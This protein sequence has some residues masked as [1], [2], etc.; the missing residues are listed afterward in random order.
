LTEADQFSKR[1]RE[2]I[3]LLLQG[4]GNKQI[5]LALGITERTVEFHL[6][7]VYAKLHVSSAREAILKLGKSTV[8]ENKTKLGEST[9]V[10]EGGSTENDVKPIFRRIPMKSLFS[11]IFGSVLVTLW[12]AH[13]YQEPKTLATPAPQQPA[14]PQVTQFKLSSGITQ[15]ITF[16]VP[17]ARHTLTRLTNGKILMVGGFS[18]ENVSLVEVDLFDPITGSLT[19]VAPLHTPRHDHSATLLRDGRVLVVGGYNP[20]QQWL[21]DAE[22]YDPFTDTWTVVPPLYSHGTAHTATLLKDGR[23]LVVGGG[24]GSGACTERAE[25][26]DPQTNSWI[27]VPSLPAQRTGHTADLLNDGRVLIAGGI[28]AIGLTVGGDGFLYDPKANHWVVTG[29]MVKERGYASSVQLKNGR[30]LVAGGIAADGTPVW[31]TIANV[32][33]YD[34]ASNTWSKTAS[35]SE[36]RYAYVLSL[37]PNGQ[38]VAVGGTRDHDSNWSEGSFVSEVEVYD[39]NANGWQTWGEIPQPGA[40]AAAALFHDGRLWV[41]GGY[42]GPSGG[43][44]SQATWILPPIPRQP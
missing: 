12:L 4:K 31:H 44:I 7:N 3:E 22:V 32:E 38:V 24:I 1:Q 34:P 29:P 5:A 26:F 35:L 25:L 41:T 2:V 42:T 16:Q 33:I 21:T 30:V 39:P 23:V 27:E 43:S 13:L 28:N 18:G 40:F 36:G 6:Q 14:A 9:V 37:L 10:L 19:P 20:Q 17:H 8:P 11:I 15:G